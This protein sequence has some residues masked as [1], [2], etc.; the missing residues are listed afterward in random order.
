MRVERGW[1]RKGE[2]TRKRGPSGSEKGTSLGSEEA[3]EAA[4]WREGG[5]GDKRGRVGCSNER[6]LHDFAC[7]SAP[8]LRPSGFSC[9][10]TFSACFSGYDMAGTRVVGRREGRRVCRFN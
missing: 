8:R 10:P 6:N 9:L 7:F 1:W 4:V 5:T 2:T 3:S